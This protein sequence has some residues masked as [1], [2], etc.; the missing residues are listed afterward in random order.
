M[1]W[2][3]N[4]LWNTI[5]FPC[6]RKCNCAPKLTK[7]RKYTQRK[8]GESELSPWDCVFLSVWRLLSFLYWGFST[9][10][11]WFQDQYS[12]VQQRIET[13]RQEY[14]LKTNFDHVQQLLEAYR[15]GEAMIIIEEI[16]AEDPNYPGLTQPW[17][18]LNLLLDLDIRYSEAIEKKE[19]GDL[20]GAMAIL[21]TIEASNPGYQ[22]VTL[23]IRAIQRD[24]S[25]TDLIDLADTAVRLVIG[26][27][28]SPDMKKCA[29]GTRSTRPKLSKKG[30]TSVI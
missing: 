26:V 21:D 17:N 30:C 4:T 2:W 24:F 15:P 11:D 3:K 13:D 1:S 16:R 19:D 7:K 23:Q 9:Y 20:V 10:N 5:C 14:E 25:M 8:P 27:K 12:V 18:G 29:T 6:A 22:D 28:P